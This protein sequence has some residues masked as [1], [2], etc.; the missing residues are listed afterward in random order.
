[1]WLFWFFVLSIS[2]FSPGFKDLYKNKQITKTKAKEQKRRK[3]F[4]SLLLSNFP[5]T[6]FYAQ[7][8]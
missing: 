1:M 6:L 7:L 3:D 4:N 2:A 8:F 5:G